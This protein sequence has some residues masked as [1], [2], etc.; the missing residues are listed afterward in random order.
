MTIEN[1]LFNFVFLGLNNPF[2]IQK[3]EI[4]FSSDSSDSS[5]SNGDNSP[6]EAGPRR[7]NS[8]GVES[9]QT[10]SLAA[11]TLLN[12]IQEASKIAHRIS[13]FVVRMP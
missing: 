3:S 4:F 2:F 13:G 5:A 1:F 11:D 12:G 6:D 9:Q 7:Y 10:S 8:T